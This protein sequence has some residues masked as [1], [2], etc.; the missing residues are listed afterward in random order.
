MTDP[1]ALL[2][3]LKIDLRLSTDAYDERLKAYLENA[4]EAITRE[5]ATLT[6][7]AEDQMLVVQYAAWTWRRRDTG[8]AMPR[9]IRWALNNR[10]FS[11]HME[12][13]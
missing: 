9:M 6:D 8:E 1:T 12:G 4:A 7:S 13:A 10:I 5:G 11:Q 3:A 2:G